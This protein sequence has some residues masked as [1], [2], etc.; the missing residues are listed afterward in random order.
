[1]S[2]GSWDYVSFRVRDIAEALLAD[3]MLDRDYDPELNEEQKAARH[4]LGSLLALVS[5]AL[6]AIEWVDSHDTS[7]PSDNEAI[8]KVFAYLQKESG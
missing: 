6:Y 1:M 2:G 3:K 4:K 5:D 7:T 8:E